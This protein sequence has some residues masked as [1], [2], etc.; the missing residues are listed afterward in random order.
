MKENFNIYLSPVLQTDC[1]TVEQLH[2]L[3]YI[4]RKSNH[5]RT[6]QPEKAI[7]LDEERKKNLQICTA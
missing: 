1:F 7:K 6:S 5:V 2:V 3:A 4:S